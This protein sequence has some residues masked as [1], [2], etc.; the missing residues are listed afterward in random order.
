MRYNMASAAR[1]RLHE[2]QVRVAADHLRPHPRQ[3]SALSQ[4]QNKELCYN[5][6]KRIR[7]RVTQTQERAGITNEDHVQAEMTPT[8]ADQTALATAD[9]AALCL[10][11]VYSD[12]NRIIKD[13]NGQSPLYKTSVNQPLA[14]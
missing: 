14:F 1:H 13:D 4:Q 9:P 10:Y 8:T 6:M 12:F 5:N 11:K 3:H 2:R 7:T